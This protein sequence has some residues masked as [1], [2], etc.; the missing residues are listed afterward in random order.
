MKIY[1]CYLYRR[2]KNYSQVVFCVGLL[3]LSDSALAE[4]PIFELVI[5]DH[6]FYPSELIVPAGQKVKLLISNE[7]A[8]QIGRAHV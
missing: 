8:T 2:L 5:R 6:L 1:N 7:D 3:L 4:K